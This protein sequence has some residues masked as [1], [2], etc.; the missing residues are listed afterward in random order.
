MRKSTRL[1]SSAGG[2]IPPLRPDMTLSE[3]LA[4]VR[5]CIEQ[6]ATGDDALFDAEGSGDEDAP[7]EE[8]EYDDGEDDDRP[9]PGRFDE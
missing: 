6:C 8:D 5:A 9:H 2:A 4:R 1:R 7:H 3:R